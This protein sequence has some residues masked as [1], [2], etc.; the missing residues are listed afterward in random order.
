MSQADTSN[1]F[2]PGRSRDWTKLARKIIYLPFLL[3]WK[4][5][6][7]VIMFSQIKESCCHVFYR[8]S[9]VTTA[10]LDAMHVLRI[11]LVP[12]IAAYTTNLLK[13]IFCNWG[14]YQ[15]W[16]RPIWKPPRTYLQSLRTYFSR[17]QVSNVT[18]R[19]H[20]YSCPFAYSRDNGWCYI[21]CSVHL[22]QKV[23]S[24]NWCFYGDSKQ[25]PYPRWRVR[26]ACDQWFC[27]LI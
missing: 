5:L 17:Q 16:N 20:T 23:H 13:L 10:S 26:V 15:V 4:S 6:M 27:F 12:T 18:A 25:T 14:K 22:F 24:Q 11:Y 9:G 3:F 21:L 2:K 19:T 8:L 1:A 7:Y